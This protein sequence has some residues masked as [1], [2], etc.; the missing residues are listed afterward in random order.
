M[1]ESPYRTIEVLVP[2]EMYVSPGLPTLRHGFPAVVSVSIP[3]RAAA[4]RPYQWFVRDF[5]SKR[6]S[7]YAVTSLLDPLAGV[8]L[9]PAPTSVPPFDPDRLA[10]TAAAL[11]RLQVGFFE[12]NR[13]DDAERVAA[14]ETVLLL[15]AAQALPWLTTYCADFFSWLG[16][17][18]D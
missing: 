14:R 13:L 7:G 9:P 18:V 17:Q 16:W 2:E 5:R 11:G 15:V 10:T 8:T 3:R 12:G 6:L 1:S 4:E